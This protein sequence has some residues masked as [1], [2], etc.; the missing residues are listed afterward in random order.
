MYSAKEGSF[1][2]TEAWWSVT[3][4]TYC[5]ETLLRGAPFETTRA[6]CYGLFVCRLACCVLEQV[7]IMEA[8][9]MALWKSQ[10]MKEIWVRAT[11]FEAN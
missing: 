11:S 4:G 1:P 9:W 7:Y 10:Q 3:A 2:G 6:A 5:E 8:A